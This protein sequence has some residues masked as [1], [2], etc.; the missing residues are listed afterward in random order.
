MNQFSNPMFSPQMQN[1][2]LTQRANQYYQPQTNG[3]NWVQGIEGAKAWQ[4]SPNSNVM[5][6]DS[7]NDGRFYIKVSDNVGMCTLRVFSYTEITDQSKTTIP[8]IDL[9][10]Y[11]KKSELQTLITSMLGGMSN[12][13]TVSTN[14][15]K[16]KPLITK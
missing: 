2:Y 1:P 16:P 11:V 5:L 7:E 3:I 13:S 14:D 8:N 9:S 6:L 12:E 15:G 10:E 4:L